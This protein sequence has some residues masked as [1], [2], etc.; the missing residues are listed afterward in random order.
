MHI[1]GYTLKNKQLPF[2]NGWVRSIYTVYTVLIAH[3]NKISISKSK[4]KALH[5]HFLIQVSYLRWRGRQTLSWRRR[6]S[7]TEASSSA[8]TRARPGCLEWRTNT[9]FGSDFPWTNWRLDG[10][11]FLSV[12][13][14]NSLSGWGSR[15][16]EPVFYCVNSCVDLRGRSNLSHVRPQHSLDSWGKDRGREKALAERNPKENRTP[17]E[18]S[19]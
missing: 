8:T 16:T 3:V 19:N 17:V 13:L 4:D 9:A 5:C 15:P 11:P 18:G 6:S 1:A 12:I 7:L 10:F 2:K 14:S